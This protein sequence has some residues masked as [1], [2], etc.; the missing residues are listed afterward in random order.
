MT[1]A[2]VSNIGILFQYDMP[3][4]ANP[5]L[6][7]QFVVFSHC[8]SIAKAKLGTNTLPWN[9]RNF[10]VLGPFQL[11]FFVLMLQTIW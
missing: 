9:V 6:D 2:Q 4:I 3:A 5:L 1:R 7:P 8:S 11:T 10:P